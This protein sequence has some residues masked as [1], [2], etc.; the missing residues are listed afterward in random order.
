MSARA[1]TPSI[2]AIAFHT[3]PSQPKTGM[4]I[5]NAVERGRASRT[6]GRDCRG[7]SG[8]TN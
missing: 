1:L 6:P 3:W 8:V 7:Q 5:E 4:E 2:S